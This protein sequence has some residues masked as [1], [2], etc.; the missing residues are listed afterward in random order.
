MEE[1]VCADPKRE[2]ATELCCEQD[3]ETST[4]DLDQYA[5]RYCLYHAERM[6]YGS[7]SSRCETFNKVSCS[8][9]R[10]SGGICNRDVGRKIWYSWTPLSCM[11]R[12]KINFDSGLIGRVDF[13]E[14]DQAGY[15]NVA[16]HVDQ[17]TMNFFKVAWT[18]QHE[19][20]PTDSSQCDAVLNCYS[21]NDGCICDTSVTTSLVFESASDAISPENLYNSLH[22]GVFRPEM[23]GHDEIHSLG[24]CNIDGIEV[25]SFSSEDSCSSFSIN[26]IFGFVD[27]QGVQRYLKNIISTV[28]ILGLGESF[29]NVPHFISM[30]DQDL[31]DMHYETDA[32][33]DHFIHH[34]SHAPFLAT[35]MIQRFGISNP[36]PGFVERVAT[37][38]INGV[39]EGVGSGEYG[40]LSALVTAILLDRESR[41]TTLDADPSHGQLRE[42]MLKVTSLYR[43]MEVTFSSPESWIQHQYAAG[44]G[45]D[46][47]GSPS[48]FSFF[49]PEYKPPGPIN[50]ADLVAPES[51]VLT[52]AKVTTLLDGLLS[53]IKFG[54][55]S[56]YNAFG[57]TLYTG[58]CPIQEGNT[59]DAIGYLDYSIPQ[60]LT[61]DEAIEDLALLL[62][63]GRLS[64]TN[65]NII[66]GAIE[67][68]YNNGDISKATRIAQQLVL[69]SPEFHTWG[70]VHRNTGEK[71]HIQGYN[72][73]PKNSY[74]TVV[75]FMMTGKFHFVLYFISSFAVSLIYCLFSLQRWG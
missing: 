57:D 60:G 22:V 11:T 52:G 75:L 54:L 13:P 62:T 69:S 5:H 50:N 61:V 43:S 28:N 42:P 4:N 12:V 55:V 47:Y 59:D 1:S 17:S 65:R 73:P 30:V 72:H 10:F 74:K 6:T 48:V 64:S 8:P 14:P 20:L 68:E 26:T 41:S 53:T 39:C 45:Q 31:R 67:N 56:C 35:R 32:V 18:T 58:Q 49:L 16:A 15:R 70:T 66:R 29:R 2:V 24:S 7:A 19:N 23:Y 46:P 71:R 36:S 44:I 37:S 63:G 40:D 51:Q 34:P 21:T 3:W 9:K 38:Y 27:H 25:L 33:I